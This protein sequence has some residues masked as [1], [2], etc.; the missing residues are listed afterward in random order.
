MKNYPD[1]QNK[2]Q[3]LTVSE[4]MNPTD[5][6]QEFFWSY[7]LPE[8]RKHCWD[9]LVSTLQDEDV[10]AGYSVMFYENLM[11]FI[12]AGSLLCKKNNEAINQSHENEN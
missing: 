10:N 6:M 9:F 4:M 1:W 3:M 2:P 12:E 5:T 7:D 11:K 8:I